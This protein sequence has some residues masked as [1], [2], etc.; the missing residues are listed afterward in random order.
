MSTVEQTG[1][2]DVT[3]DS[4]GDPVAAWWYRPAA[5]AGTG[6][7]V[8]MAHGFSLT[9]HDG[10][11][12]F[13]QA[14][15]DAGVHVLLFDHRYLGDSGGEPR[16][17]FR[18]A[19]QRQDW[20]RAI[21]HART[22]E[23]VDPAKIV[24]WGYSFSGGHVVNQLLRRDDIAA[25]MVLCPFVDGLKRVFAT[26]PGLTAWIVPRALRDIA[27][28]H[29]LIPVT[30]QPGSHGAMSL[31][32]EADGFAKAVAP[33]SPWRNEISPGLFLTV[34]LHRPVTKAARI[35]CP[36]WVGLGEQDISVDGGAVVRLAERAP[37]GEL[38]RYP[39]DHWLPFV[40][41]APAIIAADQVTFLR[42]QGLAS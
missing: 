39:Y 34:G 2:Q 5:G 1:R 23:G 33:G 15:A 22:L 31:E 38:H 26:R 21:D 19:A 36:L 41:D 8:V 30:G 29:N 28:G 18:A 11:P 37:K 7:C 3:F 35:A 17:R 42:A 25:A 40:G 13:A 32:G 6:A 10:L 16:Q 24:L 12:I 4:G 20:E 14:F 9:R 27:G